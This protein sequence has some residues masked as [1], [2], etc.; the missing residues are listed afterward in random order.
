MSQKKST[1]IIIKNEYLPFF[2]IRE[3]M[4]Q[5]GRE[6]QHSDRYNFEHF[7]F[8]FSNYHFEP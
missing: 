2:L 7:Y 3:T 1:K 6:L 4:S 8:Y 5:Y